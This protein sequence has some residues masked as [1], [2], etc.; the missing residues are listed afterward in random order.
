MEEGGGER[1]IEKGSGK[2]GVGRERK[3][4]REKEGGRGKERERARECVCV[5]EK[6]R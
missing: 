4:T 3:G 6:D 2:E 1:K 5:K